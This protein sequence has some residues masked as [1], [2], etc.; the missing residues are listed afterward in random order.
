MELKTSGVI[1]I[2]LAWGIIFS[3]VSYCFYNVLKSEKNK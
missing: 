2:V 1:F 3:L